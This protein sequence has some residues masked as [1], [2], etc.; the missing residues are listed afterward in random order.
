MTRGLA[1]G[2]VIS[3][4]AARSQVVISIIHD[5]VRICTTIAE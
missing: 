4:K 5:N 3:C 1:N 2:I